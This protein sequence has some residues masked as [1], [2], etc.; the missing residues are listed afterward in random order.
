MASLDLLTRMSRLICNSIAGADGC[1]ITV[2][3]EGRPL[4][5]AFPPELAALDDEFQRTTD[6]GP[7]LEA[8]SSQAVVECRDLTEEPRWGPYPAAALGCGMRS[9]LSLPMDAAGAGHGALN[10]Y[11]RTAAGFDDEDRR[12][13]REFADVTEIILAA[14][15]DD[16]AAGVARRWQESLARRTAV[17]QAVGIVMARRGC[18]REKAFEEMVEESRER[19]EEIHLTAVRM[20]ADAPDIGR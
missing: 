17:A 3:Y 1:G 20:G 2:L 5:I 11:S 16:A 9:V 7:C 18:D 4:T 12:A 10:L 19:G 14:G 8:L 15:R 6:D 13:G